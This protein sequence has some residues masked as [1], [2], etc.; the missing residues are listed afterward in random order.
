VAPEVVPVLTDP[1]PERALREDVHAHRREVALRLLRLLLPLDDLV[2]LV[3]REDPH[4]GRLDERHPADRDRDVGAV[5]AMGRDERLVIHLVDVV[6]GEDEDRVGRLVLD[7]VHVLEHRVRGAA[8]PLRHAAAGDVRLEQLHAAAVT[9]EVPRPAEADV[10]VEG[11]R[12]VLGQ[13]DHVVDVRVH[14]VGQREIDDPVLAAERDRGLGTN[15]REDRET[16]A[17]TAGEDH[18]HGPLHRAVLPLPADDAVGTML[19][20]GPASA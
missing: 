13:D 9:V 11:T 5:A 19:A 20:R 1:A 16:L 8:V 7:D 6:A 18:R 12:V 17:L 2:R 14:A 4:P 15:G 10:V 3:H